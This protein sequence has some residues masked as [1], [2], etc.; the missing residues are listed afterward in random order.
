MQPMDQSSTIIDKQNEESNKEKFVIEDLNNY[1]ENDF[2][3]IS[4]KVF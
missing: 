4:R 1:L 3:F 2:L